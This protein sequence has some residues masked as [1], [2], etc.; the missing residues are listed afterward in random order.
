[1]KLKSPSVIWLVLHWAGLLWGAADLGHAQQPMLIV[2]EDNDHYFKQKAELMTQSDLEAYIDQFARTKVT[3]FFMCPNGQRTSYRSA[4]HE[5][6]WDPV[7]GEMPNDVWCVNAKILHDKGIDPYE[8]WIRR[9]RQQG[10]SPWLTMRMNDVHFVTTTNYFRNTTFWRTRP[11]L[12]RVPHATSGDWTDYAFDYSHQEVREYHLALV[13][14]LFQRYDFDGFE[15]DWMRFCYHLTPGKEEEQASIL[16][17]FTR[18]VRKIAKAWETKRGHPIR[19]CARIPSHPDAAAGLGMDGIQWA[20]QGLVDML[21]VSPF[22]SSSD[23][24]IPVDLWKQR[25]GQ[26]AAQVAIV[27]AIDNGLAPYPGAP[28][29]D[30][31]LALLYG[32]AATS[33][34]RGAD[35]LY[36]FN[37]VYFPLDKPKFRPILDKGLGEH[38]I[39][40]APRRHPVCYRDTVPKGFSNGAQLPKVLDKA[41][42]F[43][44][45]TG[46]KPS[47][48]KAVVLIGLAD[49]AGLKDATF[50][51]SLNGTPSTA[52]SDIRDNLKRYGAKTVRAL[53][54]EFSLDAACDGANTVVITANAGEPQQIIWAEIQF[55]P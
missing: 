13:R 40:N 25:L 1:M 36:L 45:P 10:I 49:K 44:I 47:A 28:R 9:C 52:C 55:A 2:N 29:I 39:L 27:P 3:H 5:A 33:H 6:I 35:S 42:S 18:E 4:V 38:T 20:K 34:Y 11:D 32:W 24:D 15:L 41:A 51:A 37:W 50:G 21:V 46:K 23:F 22:F 54:F 53:G 26:Q 16:T 43:V 31:D 8:V 48:G 17:N 7:A 14:E 30:N 19:L 12:W